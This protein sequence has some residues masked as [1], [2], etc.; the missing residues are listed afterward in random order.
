VKMRIKGNSV[1][2]R[3]TRSEV[4]RLIEEGSIE[5]TTYFTS[6]EGASLT[7]VLEHRTGT[8]A[9]ELLYQPNRIVVALPDEL[10]RLWAGSEQVGIYRTIDLGARGSLELIIEKDF[11]CLDLSDEENVDT[12]PHPNAGATC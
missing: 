11:A 1:R 5:E 9:P 2:L 12:F 7:Y 6:A 4:A 10:A 8:L 3:I